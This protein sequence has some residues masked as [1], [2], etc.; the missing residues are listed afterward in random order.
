M[1]IMICAD[2]ARTANSGT[3]SRGW[4]G[5]AHLGIEP[6]QIQQGQSRQECSPVLAVGCRCERGVGSDGILHLHKD[7]PWQLPGSPEQTQAQLIS[8][9]FVLSAPPA[10][11]SL[12]SALPRGAAGDASPRQSVF[13][14]L[15][16]PVLAADS[17]V[18]LG[19]RSGCQ[20]IP[21][22]S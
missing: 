12:G 13:Y 21:S 3:Q 10:A 1:R 20:G 16:N 17:S 5:K 22:S 4:G 2:G 8:R 14:Q 6:S 18:P 19:N 11:L 15:Q 9:G 7:V